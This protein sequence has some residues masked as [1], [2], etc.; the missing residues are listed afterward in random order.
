MMPQMKR[1]AFFE[2]PL[3]SLLMYLRV[4]RLVLT[5]LAV[6][7]CVLF[8]ANDAYLRDFELVIPRDCVAGQTRRA[9]R[10]SLEYFCEVL[11]VRTGPS[12]GLR[13]RAGE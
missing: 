7:G 8:T 9:E 12:R 2:S 4:R 10:R 3:D 6:E 11:R 13:L 1:S 5:G